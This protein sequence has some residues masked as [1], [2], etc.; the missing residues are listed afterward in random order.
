M[1]SLIFFVYIK[2]SYLAPEYVN[3]DI[4]SNANYVWTFGIIVYEI[5]TYKRWKNALFGE[6]S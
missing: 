4:I 5:L 1:I 6:Y 2:F 3:Q